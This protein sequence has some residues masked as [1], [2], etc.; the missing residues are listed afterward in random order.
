MGH[1]SPAAHP[2]GREVPGYAPPP[3][4]SEMH[5]LLPTTLPEDKG[6]ERRIPSFSMF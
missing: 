3:M 5:A 1:V 6:P 2:W 4:Q